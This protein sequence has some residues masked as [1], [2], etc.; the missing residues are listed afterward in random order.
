VRLVAGLPD[1]EREDTDAL[2]ALFTLCSR[3]TLRARDLA[4]AIQKSEAEADAVL[5]RLAHDP[6]GLLEPTRET[7][8]LR[9]STYR[10]RADVLR[11]LGTAAGITDLRRRTLTEDCCVS[12]VRMDHQPHAAE[13]PTSTSSRT[14][15]SRA[16]CAAAPVRT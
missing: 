2:L 3:R 1:V 16:S 14:R 12:P 11:A 8:G 9:Q 6:P 13:T 5:Q 4:P 15:S 7:Q 10:L